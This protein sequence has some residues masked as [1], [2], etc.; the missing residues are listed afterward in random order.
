[1]EFCLLDKN[2][3]PNFS[4]EKTIKERYKIMSKKKKRK[5]QQNKKKLSSKPNFLKKNY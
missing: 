5:N 3:I 2:E 4:E 1:L